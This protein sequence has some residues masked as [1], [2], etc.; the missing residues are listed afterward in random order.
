MWL[1]IAASQGVNSAVN[2]RNI[3]ERK[4]S[5]GQIE[6]AQQMAQRCM[7]SNYKQCDD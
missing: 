1:N 6:T 7:S 3:V 2:I 5:S 4:M